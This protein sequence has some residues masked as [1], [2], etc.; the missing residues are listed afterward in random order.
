MGLHLCQPV[1]VWAAPKGLPEV[2]ESIESLVSSLPE[3]LPSSGA[4][5]LDSA[6]GAGELEVASVHSGGSRTATLAQDT[7]PNWFDIVGEVQTDSLREAGMTDPRSV[8]TS[9]GLP[10]L[11]NDRYVQG[12]HSQQPPCQ[13][14]CLSVV[15]SP[16][17]APEL[18]PLPWQVPLEARDAERQ[19]AKHLRHDCFP[20][21]T[22][23]LASRPQPSRAFA[24]FVA[25][26]EWVTYAGLSGVVMDARAS[27]LGQDGPVFAAYLSRPTTAQEIC[28]EAGFYSI[29]Q[30]V[31]LVGS[32][33]EQLRDDEQVFLQNGA[34]VRLIRAACAD[35][36]ARPAPSLDTIIADDEFQ[37]FPGP[38]PTIPVPRALMLL[39]A[40]GRS[41]FAGP[42]SPGRTIH[43]DIIDFVGVQPGSVTFHSPSDGWAERVSH[44]GVLPRGI[45]VLAD[46][47]PGPEQPIVVFLDLRPVAGAIHFICPQH[48]WLGYADL[49][50]LLPRP[51]PPGWRL[52][53]V[54]G[55]RRDDHLSVQ[56]RDTLVLGLVSVLDPEP[57][58]D[59]PED[60]GPPDGW[61][62]DE[63]GEEEAHT[64]DQSQGSTR[65]RSRTRARSS[66]RAAGGQPSPSSDPSFE[67]SFQRG[68]DLQPPAGLGAKNCSW[69][70]AASSPYPAIRSLPCHGQ[71]DFALGDRFALATLEHVY[72]HRYFGAPWLSPVDLRTVYIGGPDQTCMPA[73]SCAA[74]QQR[75][76]Q[77]SPFADMV[78][79][80]LCEH[81]NDF[82]MVGCRLPDLPP[83]SGPFYLDSGTAA[84]LAGTHFLGER[85]PP[86]HHLPFFAQPAPVAADVVDD[87]PFQA[88]ALVFV[89]EYPPDTLVA[90]L[91][92]GLD[93]PTAIARFQ[94]VRQAESKRRFDR[95]VPARP[96][97]SMHYATFLAFADWFEGTIALFDCTRYNGTAYSVSVPPVMNRRSLL[98]VAG[99]RPEQGVEVYVADRPFP[100]QDADAVGMQTGFT[101]HFVLP[102]HSPFAVAYFEDLLLSA[103][104]WASHVDPPVLPDHWLYLVSDD[105]PS[106]F[107]V[108]AARRR[109]LREDIAACLGYQA[110]QM[111]IIPTVP[112]L[113]DY[114]DFGAYAQHVLIV[115]QFP[116]E[117]PATGVRRGSYL[118]DLR[119]LHAGLTWGFASGSSVRAQT[120]VDRFER[121]CP[122]S[123]YVS[124]SGATP[125]HEDAGLFFDFEPG[126]VL[127]VDFRV[128]P[129]SSS[130]GVPSE[131]ET[132]SDSDDWDPS[133]GPDFSGRRAIDSSAGA[134]CCR[135]RSPVAER[136]SSSHEPA[137]NA[138]G[139]CNRCLPPGHSEYV[140]IAA[141]S[142]GMWNEVFGQQAYRLGTLDFTSALLLAVGG[143]A[144]SGLALAACWPG[145]ASILLLCGFWHRGRRHVDFLCFCMVL[146]LMT[147]LLPRC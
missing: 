33:M 70:Q 116:L 103:L 139:L 145:G 97:L 125:R 146:C 57:P 7:T 31:I 13:V 136:G 94:A 98:S 109:L 119:P 46:R 65:S 72:R 66:S 48:P 6:D 106:F 132:S 34:L 38:P 108:Q 96:Q 101:V 51:I 35:D 17:Y 107:H 41:F 81:N 135:S 144:L 11:P 29:G 39:H 19:V 15:V 75:V 52:T 133:D 42:R 26:P 91:Q 89:P 143:L 9:T 67:G 134:D 117:D 37:G 142:R 120:L 12:L 83:P 74:M 82:G 128:L 85:N 77:A 87:G 112:R 131:G 40:S 113:L 141:W 100:L 62:E 10:V 79:L 16:G 28:R 104:G 58:G 24:T 64:D 27:T 92:V 45:I 4:V 55:N 53:A 124:I 130:D 50:R 147:D 43:S 71:A 122:A 110:A 129:D 22:Q 68:K 25:I 18:V 60:P 36:W 118:L 86:Q 126:Q 73:V 99:I 102:N 32:S 84:A 76:Q 47:V 23:V 54:G 121:I 49:E 2:L 95:L 105:A 20:F 111:R 140:I 78:S 44:R 14:P 90:E 61:D 123:H 138:H 30:C 93:V 3:P 69:P 1:C 137:D 21:S 56:H 63:D 88:I 80:A 8:P 59:E 5:V 114:C 127:T 115:T